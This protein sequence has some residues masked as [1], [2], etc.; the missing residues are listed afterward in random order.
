MLSV[1]LHYRK[2]A[3]LPAP[4]KAVAP[5]PVKGVPVKINTVA[6]DL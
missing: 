2:A 5:V 3:A 6:L 4:A 1:G